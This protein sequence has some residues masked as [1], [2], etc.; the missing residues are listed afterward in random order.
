MAKPSL[1]DRI[2]EIAEATAKA[3]SGDYSVPIEPSGKN[4]QLDVLVQAIHGLI[5]RS[6][7]AETHA[8]ESARIPEQIEDSCSSFFFGNPHPM[9]VYDLETLSFLAVNDAAVVKYGYSRQEFLRMTIADIRPGEDLPRL[10]ENIAQVKD[11][12]DEAGIWRH[13]L[14]NESV[15]DV[16]I[17]SHPITFEGRRAELVLAQDVTLRRRADEHMRERQVFIE[18]LLENAPIG[19]AVNSISDGKAV[20]ISSKFEEIY[21]VPRH[22]VNTVDDFF[23]QVYLDP[24]Y[25]DR[26]RARIAADMLSREPSRMRWENIPIVTAAGERRAVTAVNIPLFEQNLMISTVQDVTERSRMEEA[27]RASEEMYRH[28]VELSFNAILVHS[29]G[30]TVFINPAGAQLLGAGN[31]G[32]IIGKP[33]AEILHPDFHRLLQDRLALIARTGKAPLVEVK[34]VGLDGRVVDVEA[35]AVGIS[36]EDKPAVMVVMRD[37]SERKS[38]ERQISEALHYLR[39]IIDRSPIGIITYRTTGEAISANEAAARI[40]GGSIEQ[41]MQT[42]FREIQCWKDSGLLRAAGEA[43]ASETEGRDELEVTTTFGKKIWLACRFV[44]FAHEAE[45]HL[46]CLFM[47]I[48]ENKNAATERKLLEEQL[49]QAQKLESVGR[50]AGGVAHDFNNMLT[51]ILG[52]AEIARSGLSEGDPQLENLMEIESAALRS[53]DIIRQLLA[54]SRK[55]IIA[56]TVLDLN[57]VTE[58]T[59]KP[60]SRLIGEDIELEFS[61]AQDLG[62]IRFDRSQLDQVLINL[63]V[64]ARDAMPRGGKLTIATSNAHIDELYCRQHLDAVPGPYVLLTVSDTGIGMDDKI[65]PHIFEPFFT[66]K[67]LGKGTGLGLATVYGIVKQNRGFIHVSS[68]GGHGSCF[69]IYIPRVMEA[70]EVTELKEATLPTTGIETVLLVEDEEMVRKMTASMLASIGYRVLECGTPAEAL[71]LCAAPDQPIELLITDVVLPEMDGKR[72]KDKIE[73]IRPGIKVLFTSG[74]TS[75]VI[76]HRGVSDQGVHF[77]QK[78]FSQKE[79]ARKVR[80]ALGKNRHHS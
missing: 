30:V 40:F 67:D 2:A 57:H 47:D 75:E 46:L 74:Y 62:K 51:V 22:S 43:L 6:R 60:L 16:E 7:N 28:L 59:Q 80:E 70:A 72:L 73:L 23:E 25:R 21:G 55:Q 12:L 79:L 31:P 52:Y 24:E 76:V 58:E 54:F 39:T 1:A 19:I 15:I 38:A 3:A 65:L 33:I 50:L 64:N 32:Q 35:A 8:A 13:H 9:W 11:G 77:L 36:H 42:N 48:T 68:E 53:R 61:P 4:D 17:T 5:E 20:F 41:L 14:K 71:A 27:L 63:A 69:R 49:I 18:T 45:P 34:F 44:P 10:M 66:T 56:P 78:P 29:G 26:V 37:I